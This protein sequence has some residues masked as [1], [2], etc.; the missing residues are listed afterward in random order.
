M[1]VEHRLGSIGNIHRCS[2]R[3][4]WQLL[5]LRHQRVQLI[6]IDIL[7]AALG[8]DC[9]GTALLSA[10]FLHKRHEA[11][12]C[13]AEDALQRD[14]L[15]RIGFI[16]HVE[17]RF[18]AFRKFCVVGLGFRRSTLDQLIAFLERFLILFIHEQCHKRETFRRQCFRRF[19][20]DASVLDARVDDVT[21]QIRQAQFADRLTEQNQQ[22]DQYRT[23]KRF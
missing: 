17:I 2:E 8:I 3:F 21:H 22:A 4:L 19:L 11:V 10:H 14:Q 9:R 20:F 23:G 1:A 16:Q 7:E 12:A 15:F 6:Q 13:L 5:Q 18:L